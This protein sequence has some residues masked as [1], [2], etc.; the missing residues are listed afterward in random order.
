MADNQLEARLIDNRIGLNADE[1]ALL[2]KLC[3][4]DLEQGAKRA[5]YEESDVNR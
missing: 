3:D 5:Q 2:D 1:L 4:L